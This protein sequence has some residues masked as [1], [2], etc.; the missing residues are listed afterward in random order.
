MVTPVV[1]MRSERH[2]RTQ[3]ACIGAVNEHVTIDC[4]GGEEI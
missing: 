3:A 2:A 1:E 4:G